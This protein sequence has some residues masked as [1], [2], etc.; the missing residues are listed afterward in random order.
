MKIQEV[1]IRHFRAIESLELPLHPELTVLFGPNRCGKTSGLRAIARAVEV[2]VG[3]FPGDPPC[4]ADTYDFRSG[5]GE[6]FVQL[7]FEDKGP[8]SIHG[9]REESVGDRYGHAEVT[10]AIL[11]EPPRSSV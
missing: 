2:S 7:A 9:N 1:T 4:L 8:I 6:P 3:R 5:D 11:N 10:E